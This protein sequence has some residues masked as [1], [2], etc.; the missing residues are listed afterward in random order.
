M[1]LS[2]KIQLQEISFPTIETTI[3]Q[4]ELLQ[5]SERSK[6]NYSCTSSSI[7][8]DEMTNVEVYTE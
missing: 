8:L 3:A 7:F 1:N 5:P 2:I 4:L 6:I